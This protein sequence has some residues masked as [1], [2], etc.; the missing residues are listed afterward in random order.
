MSQRRNHKQNLKN[1]NDCSGLLCKGS[2]L[3]R[4]EKN[5]YFLIKVSL[6]PII[7]GKLVVCGDEQ[8]KRS[9]PNVS[10]LH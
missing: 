9:I 5:C 7:I 10:N 6:E 2:G 4:I 1:I 3:K 8:M